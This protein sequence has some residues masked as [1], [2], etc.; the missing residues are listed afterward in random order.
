MRESS[1]SSGSP[2]VSP[3]PSQPR[4]PLWPPPPD[5]LDEQKDDLILAGL[6]QGQQLLNQPQPQQPPAPSTP[7]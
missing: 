4:R 5:P 1:T 2:S 7:K 3:E 6:Q